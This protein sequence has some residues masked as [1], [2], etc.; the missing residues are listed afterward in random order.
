MHRRLRAKER[1]LPVD[2][3]HVSVTL[4]CNSSLQ[5]I[6][7]VQ[8]GWGEHN[9]GGCRVFLQ[10][11]ESRG[12]GDRDQHV[13]LGKDPGEGDLRGCNAPGVCDELYARDQIQIALKI[14]CR[15]AWQ[16]TTEVIRR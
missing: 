11:F 4:A 2:P 1:V 7:Q 9:I 8:F 16:S 10:S 14:F 6:E 15:E 12:A 5:A 3:A 13:A